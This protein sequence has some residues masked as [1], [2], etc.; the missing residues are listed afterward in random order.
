MPHVHFHI[1]PRKSKGDHFGNND[2]V[3][4]ALEEHAQELQ[5]AFRSN[6]K[7]EN[8]PSGST[9]EPLKVDNE[10]RKPRSV[11]EME[12]EAAWL[13]EFSET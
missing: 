9:P 11:E 1:L 12:R 5:Q 4:P 6:A 10:D 7:R 8:E 13:K 3:Y 2:D